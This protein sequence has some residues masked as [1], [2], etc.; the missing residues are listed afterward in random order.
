MT[1]C[2]HKPA[3]TPSV[4]RRTLRVNW[5]E[6]VREQVRKLSQTPAFA[7]AR[8]AR[9]KIETLFSELRKQVRLR[10][11]RLRGLRNA[12]E[13]FILAATAQNVKRLIRYLNQTK[14]AIAG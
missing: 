2:S 1:Y 8:R 3:C 7:I 4:T 13:Q 6:D 10:K 12:K 9:N 14:E 5:Y 11:V